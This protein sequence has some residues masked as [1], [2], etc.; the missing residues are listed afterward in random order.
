M[1]DDPGRCSGPYRLSRR[2]F[3]GFLAGASLVATGRALP[4][5]APSINERMSGD[6]APVH[7]P[8]IAKAGGRYY[9]FSTGHVGDEG[10]L[11]PWRVSD[12][13][14]HW[15]YGGAV[16]D[17][18]PAW[19]EEAVPGTRG[20]WAPDIAYCNG[21]HRLYYSCSTFGS[22]RSAIGLVTNETLDPAAPGYAWRDR[23]LVTSSSREDEFNA[24]D[25]AHLE[26]R[27]GNHWLAFGSFWSGLK[28]LRLDPATGK[29]PPGAELHS[30]AARPVPEGAPGAIEAPFLIERGGWYYLFASYDYCCRGTASSYYLV[31]GRARRPLGPYAGRDGRPMLEGYGTLLL[32][33]NRDFRGPGHN[34]VLADG[35]RH[36]L[37]YHAYDA[38]RD[39]APT[40][41]ISPIEWTEDGW[42]T[43]SL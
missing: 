29:P 25:P 26:D 3:C 9:V 2:R 17:R 35:D 33:G 31:V 14:M 34:A 11:L 40:L 20:L 19:A 6:C 42:P 27:D 28:M 23:G 4:A 21:E 30:L 10:G 7:D 16:F 5:D 8:C 32:R 43:A 13:L 24:I 41:R 39:G 1:R 38:R 15:K 22:N 12:D 18:L 37:V 36:W